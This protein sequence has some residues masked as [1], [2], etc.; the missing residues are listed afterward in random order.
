MSKSALGY[1][2]RQYLCVLRR[3]AWLNAVASGAALVAV[4]PMAQA[5]TIVPDGRTQTTLS[6]NG[7][8]TDI[9][10]QT[11]RGPN[12]FNS[13]SRFDVNQGATVNLHLPGAT[14]N[15]LNLVTDQRSYINGL[16]NS[17]RNGSIGGNVYF[18]NPLGIVVG[19]GG[20]INT[21]SLT[22]AAPTPGFMNQLMDPSGTI[23]DAAMQQAL[24]GQVPLSASGLISVQ[25][26]INSADAVSLAG[27]Q[28][29]V[30]AGARVLAGGSAQVNFGDLVNVQGAQQGAGVSLDGGV[31][32]I[33]AAQDIT[34]GGQVSADGLGEQADGGSVMVMAERNA[35][36][37]AGAVVSANAASRGDGGTVE[38]SAKDTVHLAGGSLQ[39]RATQGVSGSVLIDPENV[40][41]DADLL[42]SSG[43]NTDGLGTTW[44]AGS[45]TI[46]ADKNLAVADGVVI[47]TR[48]V[49][50]NTR[51]AHIHD[52]SIGDSGDLT[53]KAAHID[54]G[55]DT[56]LLADTEAGSL[57]QAGNVTVKATDINAIGAVRSA[58]ADIK[59]EHV[60]IRGKDITLSAT[61]DTSLLAQLLETAPA[62]SLADAQTYLDN[63]LDNLSDGPGGEFLAI[64]TDA[65]ARTELLGAQ[66]KGSGDVSIGAFAGARA[67]F[68]KNAKAD[69]VIGDQMASDG[70]TVLASSRIE[71][72]NVNISSAADT[73]LTYNV[74]GSTLKLL[75][76]SWLPDPDS[77]LMQLLND[78]LFDFSSV[79]LVS[80]STSQATTRIDGA[81]VLQAADALT[82]SSSATSA[83]KPTFASPLLFSVAWGESTA[84]AMTLV[85]GTTQLLSTGKTSLTADTDVEIEVTASVD[86]K[87]KPIDAVFARVENTTVTTVDVGDNTRTDAGLVDVKANTAVEMS[88]SADAKNTG[89]SGL[90]LAL[91]INESSNTTSARLGGDV[92]A[93]TGDIAVEAQIDIAG[94][95][96]SA[97]AATLGK[98][99][100]FDTK[101]NNPLAQ[102]K[103]NASNSLLAATGKLKPGTASRISDFLFPIVKEGKFN[104]S[105]AVAYSDSVN[106][107]TAYVAPLAV[108]KAEGDLSVTSSI[109]DSPSASAGAKSSSIGSALGGSAVIANFTNNANAYLGKGSTVDAKG[110]LL[111]DANTHVP[112]PWQINWDSP[113]EI[114][115]FLQGGVLDMVLT[116]YAINSSSAK[117][118]LG[119]SAAVSVFDID[120]SANA[121]IDEGA[122]VNTVYD[123]DAQALT[124]QSVKVHAKND[125]NT[126]NAVGILSKK[127]F[128][129]SGKSAAGGSANFVDIE[130]NATA[131]IRGNA[132][133]KSGSSLDVQ[134]ENVNQLVTVTEAG[135]KAEEVG[136][137]GALS[138]NTI[139]GHATAAID[140]DAHVDTVG[141]V[142][143]AAKSDLQ[144][145]T[146]AGG[147]VATKGQ[148][149]IGFAISVNSIDTSADAYIGNYDPLGLD[150]VPATG[151]VQTDGDVKL[152]ATSL[153]EIGAYSISGAIA[154]ES[155]A[156]TEMPSDAQS[157]ETAG[158]G[159]GKG[160]FGI[161][162]SGDASVNDIQANTRA[163]ISDG[164]T[165]SQATNAQLNAGNTLAINALA[166]A[167]SVSTQSNGNGLAGSYAQNTLAGTT[168]AYLDDASLTLSS[169]LGLDATVDGTIKT[170]SASVEAT[171]GKVGVA[172]SV[173]VN[174]IGNLTQAYLK[175]ATVTGAQAAQVLAKDTS[176]IHSIAGA[177]AYAGK[178][179]VGLAF[180]WNKIHN[181]TS[182]TVDT[183]ELDASGKVEISTE[184]DNEI[185]TIA[186]AL[187]ASKSGMAA[188]GAVA[189]NTIDNTTEALATGSTL[190][191]SADQVS[192]KAQ[193][194]SD[195][196][197]ISGG[198]AAGGGQTVGVSVA[199]NDIDNTTQALA[200]GGTLSGAGVSVAAREAATMEVYAVGGSGGAKNALAGSLGV[201]TIDN[202]T[203]AAARGAVL[204]ATGGDLAVQASD[205]STINSVTGAAAVGGSN[206]VGASGSYNHIDGEVRAE[207][208]GGSATAANVLVDA[209]RAGTLDV[210]AISGSAAGTAGIAGSIALNDVGG[211]T[212]ARIGEAALVNA[213]GNALVTA[214]A[215]DYIK[216]RAGAVGLGGSAGA[217]GG[218]AFNDMHADTKAEVTGA[219]TRVTALGQGAA[220]QVDNGMLSGAGALKGQPETDA[221]KGVAVVASSTSEVENYALSA[222]G[223]GSAAVAATV[224]IAMLGGSTTAQVANG[225]R[226]N[227]AFG[228]AE[229]EAR[230][231][232]YHHDTIFSGTGGGAVGGSAGVGGAADTAVVSHT[233]RAQV[234]GAQAQAQKAVAIDAAS[235]TD[236]T[237]AVIAVGG[238][239]YVGLAGTVGV[240]LLDGTT[241]AL[242]NNAKLDSKGSVKVEATTDADV[243]LTAGA[244]AAGGVAGVGITA[245]VTVVE[246]QTRAGVSGSSALN[247]NG[248]TGINAG[249]SFEQKNDAYTAAAA[250]G[251]GVAGTVNVVVVKGSTDAAVDSGVTV[252][253]DGSY[254]GTAQD[255]AVTA[256]DD[257]RVTNRVGSLGVG[258]TAGVGAVAD[259]TLI[260][261]GASARV[262]SGASITADRDITVSANTVRDVDSTA[263]ALA[264][265]YTAGIA[266]A[267]SVISVGARPEGDAKDNTTGSVGKAGEMASASATGD[268]MGSEGIASAARADAARSSV[269][270]SQDLGAT[271]VATSAAASVVAGATLNAGRHVGVNAHN[272]T[273]TDA[274]AVGAAASGGVSIGGGIAIATVSDKTLATL[275]GTTTAGGNVNVTALDDQ[276]DEN[277]KPGESLLTTYAGG[278]GLAGLAASFALHEKSSTAGA[279]L[280]GTVKALNGS[281]TVD[282]GI[283][284]QLRSDGVAA[285]A[286]V[287]AVGASIAHVVE[288]SDATAGVN[289]GAR[290]EARSLDVHGHSQ[291]DTD[292]KV[293]AAA[294]GLISGAGADANAKDTSSAQALIGANAVVR[295]ASG[296]TQV[297]ADVDPRAKADAVGVAVAAG[298]GIGVSMADAL[299]QTT[300][301]ASTGNAVDI[302]ANALTVQ[303]ETRRRGKTAESDALAA[304][305]GALVGASATVSKASA[306]TLTESTVGAGNQLDVAGQLKVDAQSNTSVDADVTGISVGGLLAEGSNSATAKTD[307]QTYATVGNNPDL[308][309]GSVRVH[310]DG[311][312]TLR[313]NTLAGAGGLG[314]A[315]ASLGQTQAKSRTYARMGGAS[316]VAGQVDAALV[317][318]SASQHVAF[319]THADSTSASAVGFSGARA[320]NRVDTDTRATVGQNLT[321]NTQDFNAQA[322][323]D[324]LK[325]GTGYDVDSGSGGLLNGA[326]ALS[327]STINNSA[328]VDVEKGVDIQVDVAGVAAGNTNFAAHNTVNA[329]DTVRLD[330]GGAIAIAKAESVLRSETNSA[331][332]NVGEGAK[333]FSDGDIHASARADV[334]LNANA[335][336]KTYGLAGASEGASTASIGADNQ[337]NIG[338]NATVQ[339]NGENVNLMAGTNGSETNNLNANADT[340]LWNYTAIPVENDP[341]ADARI[342]Q[343]N[344]INVAGGAQV[345][346]VRSISLN[347]TEGRHTTRGFGEGTDA[348]RETLSAIGDFFGADTS[349]LKITGG[350]T[351]DNATAFG[352]LDPA[353]GVNVD[354]TVQAGIWHHQWLTLAADGQTVTTSEDMA[355]KW[356][357][358]DN[359]SLAAELSAEIAALRQE[360]QDTRAAATSYSGTDAADA[361]QA[362][363][364]DARIL[365]QQLAALAD[366]NARVGFIDVLDTTART[367][368]VNI[369]GKY[370][371]GAASGHIEAPGDVRIDIENQSTRFM[372]TNK[373]TIPDE[374]GGKV[375]FNGLSVESAAAINSRNAF[376]K[377]GG[378]GA[379]VVSA[380]TSA[381][382]VIR[383]ENTN[384]NDIP[385]LGSPAQL[386]MRGDVNNLGGEAVA[387]SHGT[388]RVSANINAETVNIATGGDFIKTYTPGFTHQGGDPIAQLGTLPNNREAAKVD[389]STNSL[390]ARTCSADPKSCSTTIA[391]NNVYISGQKLNINGI[392]QAGL[393]D[394]QMVIDAGLTG[395]ANATLISN[396]R[397]AWLAS[398]DT[399]TRYLELNN[400]APESSAIKV[401][402][403]AQ[404]DRLEL[405]NVRM[406]GGHMELFGDIFSTGNGDLRVMDGYGRIN[407]T[408][409]TGYDLAVG[410]LDTGPGVEGMIRITD[411]SQRDPFNKPLVT[412]ITRLGTTIET[413]TSATVDDD[414]NP[415]N[416]IAS[417]G[418]RSTVFAPNA[419]R[420][421]NWING[422]R[423]QT[424]EDRVYTTRVLFGIDFLWPDSDP[425]DST[426]TSNVY[427]ARL[428]GDWLSVGG[429]SADYAMDYSRYSSGT[430][431]YKA[432]KTTREGVL[433]IDGSCAK[434]DITTHKYFRTVVNEYYHHSLNASKPVAVT[435]TGFDAGDPTAGLRVDAGS[436]QLLLGGLVRDLGN[437]TTL[438]G[439]AGIQQLNDDARIVASN[440]TLTSANGAIGGALNASQGVVG[441]ENK[442]ISIDLTDAGQGLVD[443]T[444]S[445]IGRNGVSLK[446]IGGDLRVKA[447]TASNGDITLIAD[448]NLLESTP[449]TV[450]TGNNINL[451]ALSGQ[452]GDALDPFRI[453]T[454]GNVST[455]SASAAGNIHVAEQTG[456]L[457][458]V[459]VKSHAGDVALGTPGNLLDANLIETV[460]EFAKADLLNLWNEMAL[461]SGEADTALD[462]SLL[463]QQNALKK[464]YETYFRMR[465]LHLNDDGTY[466]A[467]AYRADYVFKATPNQAS[468]LKAANGWSDADLA[469]YEASQT[470]AYHASHA[471]F[472][473]G[474]YVV[475]FAPTLTDAETAALSKG[476]KWND[477]QLANA[478][479]AGLLKETSDT[480][481]RI[482]APNVTGRTVSLTAGGSIGSDLGEVVI[483][484][485]TDFGSLSDAQKLV[486]LTA[487][488]NDLTVSDTEIRI[489]QHEDFNVTSEVALNATAGSNL[490]VSS[491]QSLNIDQV[492]AVGEARVKTSETLS[493]VAGKS[494]VL[495]DSIVLEAGKGDIGSAAT[496]MVVDLGAGKLTARAGRDIYIREATGDM[497]IESVFAKGDATLVADGSILEAQTDRS[498]DVRADNINLTAGDTIGQSGQDKSLD[499]AVD[500]QG[501][502]NASAP[503]GVY[504]NSTGGSGGLGNITTAGRFEFSVD[505]GSIDVNGVVSA[506]AGVVLGAS[507]NVNFAGG[508]VR[509]SGAD[510]SLTGGMDGSG[511][512]NGDGNGVADVVAGGPVTVVA[513]NDIGGGKPLQ[514][515]VAE[516]ITLRATNIDAQV[517]PLIAGN[518]LSVTATGPIGDVAQNVNLNFTRAGP[519]VF[520]TLVLHNGKIRTD[521]ADL[522][523]VN[524][525]LGD[526]VTFV[527]PFFGARIDHVVRSTTPGL[528]VRAFTLD[529]D[530]SLT[531]TAG[532]VQLNDLIINQDLLRN[533]MGTPP[534]VADVLSAQSLQTLQRQLPR[535]GELPEP[536]ALP[537]DAPP[538][539]DVE[540]LS[541]ADL[542]ADVNPKAP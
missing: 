520:P 37:Q 371:T 242:A 13:F 42:R 351:Y 496:P 103:R 347:A 393:P 124:D 56:M 10:T 15:L 367:G 498:I 533:I 82:V 317:D 18:F 218:I 292:A 128:G 207:I 363:D 7:A 200:T 472:G 214:E 112:Y 466:S 511:S 106:S 25:G 506:D 448:R 48:Q 29:N 1:L 205:R 383:V 404:Y 281:V 512:V 30:E 531:M 536:S 164:A 236:I 71:G 176:T 471:R 3:C 54:L 505:Q 316:G 133:V 514:V 40:S 16:V 350:S 395:G 348:Y 516:V 115:D 270:L 482:E 178:G 526:A 397:A 67:G 279:Y 87:N 406:G 374:G 86:S 95:G 387:K 440:L 69:V 63:E 73:S 161:A 370:L 297:R 12:A 369:A 450:V 174:D 8:V 480:N 310:A 163:Y 462:R 93:R 477:A 530:F 196:F 199:V 332:V 537:E 515:E 255:V 60:T 75:D 52:A 127:V 365:E 185:K 149:G 6:V 4:A 44:D 296:L 380:A 495:A 464:S 267:V 27:A 358:R 191:S 165:V 148:T 325:T 388:L 250:G 22:L 99:G 490:Y 81:T 302:Q 497:V 49:A 452:I 89:G 421:F 488:R 277:G 470:Q 481:I 171:K 244:L 246:Q 118:G 137:E 143:L 416:L 2:R 179:G 91:A 151:E 51:N 101:F 329:K 494:N 257:T 458:V 129:T 216:S 150:T 77:G 345:W 433:C 400:P 436:G 540:Q 263:T 110:A 78:Q 26:Q 541:M 275:N 379:T 240:V 203:T 107:A 446:E 125:V 201:N 434:E 36:L 430:Y 136:V 412:E 249:S 113:K 390:P 221:L 360:A 295:T 396:A 158:G 5:Q 499:V 437:T 342:V 382:P 361:A 57:H 85:G 378:F 66:I 301:R 243:D 170:L 152:T 414:G 459:D 88:V 339:S 32:R 357:F 265:G 455:F 225:A 366:P 285:A 518:A 219:G 17:Y 228:D 401:R 34:V 195:I 456:D 288:D 121:W 45:L 159:T 119:I 239:G 50:G 539:V 413:R 254:G 266:G 445:A 175:A 300:A 96:T 105:G 478:I 104:L 392:I 274:T 527:T 449:G 542:P 134:A 315:V 424:D 422:E 126:V 98:P 333:V 24:N 192:L 62:T 427:S 220:A 304:A 523:V 409:T 501:T 389:Y 442:A 184:S 319:N 491:E 314:V 336:S 166:G 271:P 330:S 525:Y 222:A 11:V 58:S 438:N 420:R 327:Q 504:L 405:D 139:I 337:V 479:S 534:G 224:S 411:T 318:V 483:T 145:I 475:G 364:N 280:G 283:D 198:A 131:T 182:A 373:L 473:G 188:A 469:G 213:T 417:S 408:N 153:T 47:S 326:A 116:S 31:I 328:R 338:A 432:D 535:E 287:A 230:V 439:G 343:H 376:T 223:G 484:K 212:T 398:P 324:V 528:D 183:S 108:V 231:A 144:N 320:I 335:R 521:G 9:S 72:H 59:G 237:Q 167:V 76:Q 447:A 415:T 83:A 355:D 122:K 359:V 226:L 372:Q 308:K 156:Q 435:F 368:N 309:A 463:A 403:D 227:T 349:S 286:G 206:A 272:Q 344:T 492:Q 305:G 460:D 507:D 90:G 334:V 465:R 233:T 261:N 259:V 419:N 428:T 454:Q 120:N 252:N 229:Q 362:L 38:F 187:G 307:T 532:G 510:V 173:S 209:E 21:G 323:N 522:S 140:D 312:D 132:Q 513:A 84:Q 423:T 61:A 241:E 117:K 169:N 65:T 245:A 385:V 256:S 253:S 431:K 322:W 429:V 402:Y 457:R 453:E 142:T 190:K 425:P 321:V 391:G 232:A 64:T 193:D 341:Q 55:T 268:Q 189:L 33:V 109:T 79:P 529:N 251:V 502:I 157:T 123:K 381:A 260:H 35:T 282:A 476:H 443:G 276:H 538:L 53:L 489:A 130:E 19:Q 354:G 92:T 102:M 303:S 299:V 46:Q 294:G 211:S 68:E 508:Q 426:S 217:A 162:V 197:A 399:A 485:G 147:V 273:D 114:F 210:W 461:R 135:G 172:G 238:G 313:A 418:G 278:A 215:D 80:L 493:A 235:S 289:S 23:G 407:V 146:V 43:G 519:V 70:T 356:A 375:T 194:S 204:V 181:A 284:H 331:Q 290:I 353:S 441:A 517:S 160:K 291:T 39:A 20:V 74:V 500:A 377:Q 202:T 451:V 180:A 394:R 474:D 444:V 386:W 111:V 264:G 487:E 41:V 269:Q 14:T 524:G 503:N 352:G 155:K 262:A 346:A 340:R 168:A 141:D 234:D 247:A 467:D 97:N 94:N 248:A 486:L 293:V 410:R 208:S 186:A 468:A 384:S 298:V 306:L 138:V 258:G 509:S 311:S 177:A 100:F 154:T 28:V